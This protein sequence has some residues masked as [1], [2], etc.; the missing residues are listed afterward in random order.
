MVISRADIVERVGEWQLTEEVVEKDYVLGWLLWGFGSDPVLGDQWVFKGGTCLKKCYI[1]THRFSE[2]LDFTV[3]PGGPYRP[4]QIEPLLGRTLARVHDASGIDFSSKAPALRFRPDE[5]STEGRVYYIGPRQTPQAARVKL[6]ISANE[7]VVRPPVLREIA[8][9]YPDGPLPGRVRCYSFEEVFAE[10]IRAMAQRPDPAT[11]TTLST[12]SAATTSASTL[13]S[14]GRPSKRSVPPRALPHPSPPTLSTRRLSP[15]SKVTGPRCSPTN[16]PPFRH[17]KVSSTSSPSC[18]AGWK[19][20]SSSKISRRYRE[21]ETSWSGRHQPPSPPGAS[22]YRW[23]P[24]ASPPLTTSVSSFTTMVV[25]GSSS[26][27]RS[28]AAAPDDSSCTPSD[29][30]ATDIAPTVSTRSQDSASPPRPSDP[31]TPSSSPPK[32]SFTPH[33]R[34]EPRRAQRSDASRRGPEPRDPS[35]PLPMHTM[36]QEVPPQQTRR[37]PPSPQGPIRLPVFGPIRDVHGDAVLII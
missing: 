23:R 11:S 37:D 10:K 13:N 27:T 9:P 19:A 26:L 7:T 12:S 36:R 6:D 29:L 30:T 34:A 14:S 32:A 33:S 2:D 24:C 3:L 22:G 18:S 31:A 8:H 17:S 4:E 35:T 20:P 1:E 5:L 15:P 21:S 25:G 16:S 28:A